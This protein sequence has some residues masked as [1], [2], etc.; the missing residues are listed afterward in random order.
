MMQLFAV[1]IR[2]IGRVAHIFESFVVPQLKRLRLLLH[3]FTTIEEKEL[4]KGIKL[5]AATDEMKDGAPAA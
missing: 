5:R 2:H 4:L 1:R 3:E